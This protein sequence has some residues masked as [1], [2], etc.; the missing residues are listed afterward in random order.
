MKL[1]I[2]ELK[3][4]LPN[5]SVDPETLRDDLT[6]LGHFAS[7]LKK[8][9][10]EIV[11]DL[12]IRQNRADCLGYY[13]LALDLSVFYNINL[14]LPTHPV[15]QITDLPAS[16]A[17][18]RLPITINSP[19]VKRIQAIK[20]SD[21]KIAPSPNWLIKFLT[22][23]DINPI[24]NL[25]DLTNYAMLVYGIPCHAF[26]TAKTTDNLIWENNSKY[27]S[28]VSLDGTTL[29]LKDN[30]IISNP[31][32]CLSLG[33][34]G[35]KNSGIEN[36]TGDT[37][38]EMAIYNPT[39]IRADSRN[40]KTI[41]EASIRLDKFLDTET[42]P[43]AFAFLVDNVLK[44]C[45]GTVSSQLFEQYPQ[46]P[47][48]IFI[49]FDPS[50]PSQYAGI[51]IP[52]NFSVDILTRLGCK[53]NAN[54]VT[55]PSLRK[56]I[57]IE[58]DLIEEVIRFYGYN[59]IPLD[60]PI[61]A[62]PLAD[63]TPKI[64]HL[65][66]SLKDSLVSLGYD[67][68]RSW[69]LVQKPLSRNA[70]YTQNSINSEYPV[71]RESI[72]QSLKNQLDQFNRYKLPQPRF[73]EIG[74]IYYQQDKEYREKYALG[75]SS[76]DSD[77]LISDIESIFQKKFSTFNSQ[78]MQN[79]LFVEIILD[80]LEK[81]IAYLPKNTTNTAIELTS[82]IITLDAN[83]TFD[84]RQDPISLIRQYTKT[85]GPQYL[86]QIIVTDEYQDQPT[87]KYRYT[88]RVSYYNCD[89]KTAKQLHLKSFDLIKI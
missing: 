58:E 28:L 78:K 48:P 36:S 19:D 24:N 23:H 61:S 45:G 46:K 41:T 34:I 10:G 75:I 39:R 85:I 60:T 22:L 11:F 2:S 57:T 74:K 13:G 59:K 26:D 38:L 55:P 89:D 76:H 84:S 27:K 30:L 52:V 81:P 32:E 83:V 12:E 25:V 54:L 8:I 56:D 50:K 64:L 44:I 18:Y 3:K 49:P 63:I 86:W 43:Q 42:I 67:E 14:I 88:F 29:A 65:I 5:L 71:L 4:L 16:Q 80:D 9:D 7:G 73:F 15:L 33:F 82:Q 53:I 77:K 1:I 17:G 87:G 69:P 68:V 6:M 72:V 66:E 51:N 35:G 70:I 47:S 40:L 31:H 37:I 79:Q 21:L 20:I 62:N